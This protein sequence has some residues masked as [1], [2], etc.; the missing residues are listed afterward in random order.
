MNPMGF[1]VKRWAR[2]PPP[3]RDLDTQLRHCFDRFVRNRLSY[4]S[5]CRLEAAENWSSV[6]RSIVA[7]SQ[8]A[9][10]WFHSGIS[11]RCLGPLEILEPKERISSWSLGRPLRARNASS[12]NQTETLRQALP[13]E[14]DTG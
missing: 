8:L 9:F 4:S 2:P 7:T 12:R 14:Q 10:R 11:R 13:V 6:L 5:A 1:L 3:S